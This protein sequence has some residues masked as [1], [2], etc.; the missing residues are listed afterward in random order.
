MGKTRNTVLNHN[1]AYKL[2]K[3]LLE[4][5]VEEKDMPKALQNV[6]VGKSKKDP[7]GELVVTKFGNLRDNSAK[8]TVSTFEANVGGTEEVADKL[9]VLGD[10][11]P[12]EIK[13]V[14]ELIKTNPQKSLAKIIVEANASAMSVIKHYTQ[15]AMLLSQTSAIIEAHKHLPGVVKDIA[16]H[17][18]D[19]ED[20]CMTCVGTGEV[21]IRAGARATSK[22]CPSCSGEGRTLVS[23][24]HK[25][26]ATE[27]LLEITKMVQ[28][29]AP[30]TTVNVGVQV[31]GGASKSFFE[32]MVHTSDEILFGVEEKKLLGTG[33]IVDAEVIADVQPDPNR[34]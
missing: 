32:L 17:A 4:K 24:K 7:L 8:T 11:T 25:E 30:S 33:A 9:E 14:V 12:A 34:P 21:P 23:S 28:K 10:D 26:F 31:S 3:T 1:N 18:L 29:G 16:R 15:G 22:K 19:K 20:V 2:R 13:R 5:G 27:K 6:T